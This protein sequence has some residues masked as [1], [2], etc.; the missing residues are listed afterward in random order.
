MALALDGLNATA[1][2]AILN[3]ANVDS[4][5]KFRGVVLAAAVRGP[6]GLAVPVIMA[7]KAR[8]I[9]G[10]GGGTTSTLNQ[11]MVP[12]VSSKQDLKVDDAIKKLGVSDLVADQ[13]HTFGPDLLKDRVVDQDPEAGARVPL[14]SKVTIVVCDGAR[15]PDTTTR[16]GLDEDLNKIQQ[17]VTD[18]T[19]EISKQTQVLSTQLDNILTAVRGTGS[20][21]AT[22]ATG[23]ATG[24]TGGATGDTGATGATG[25]T[26]ASP[27][28]LGG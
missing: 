28:K 16:S 27:K 15:P 19:L 14:H 26:G 7:R 13:E 9:P 22:G 20:T 18:L 4:A 10:G 23:G 21:G 17:A 2:V 24:A 6:L 8:R 25:P 11:V 1:A 12:D 3:Q 5:T